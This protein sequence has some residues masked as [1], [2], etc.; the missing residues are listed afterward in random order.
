[1]EDKKL[2]RTR[3]E[4]WVHGYSGAYVWLKAEFWCFSHEAVN[5]YYL[6]CTRVKMI[7]G[8]CQGFQVNTLN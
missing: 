2:R 8:G 7:V 3:R 4:G 1:M 5:L 6:Y